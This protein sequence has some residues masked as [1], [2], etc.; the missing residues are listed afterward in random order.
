MVEKKN[1]NYIKAIVED[2]VELDI[3]E[4]GKNNNMTEYRYSNNYCEYGLRPWKICLVMAN[5]HS[6]ICTRD[7]VACF[8]RRT[9]LYSCCCRQVSIQVSLAHINQHAALWCRCYSIISD[10]FD[11]THVDMRNMTR[12][13]RFSSFCSLRHSIFSAAETVQDDMRVTSVG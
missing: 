3:Q 4:E 5:T 6:V 12:A 2:N 7:L 11:S 1:R 8:Y 13:R 10:K 9:S